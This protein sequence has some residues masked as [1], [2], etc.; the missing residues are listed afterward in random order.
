MRSII[1][2]ASWR[3]VPGCA[4][5]LIVAAGCFSIGQGCAAP[6]NNTAQIHDGTLRIKG[7]SG[8]SQLA[9][10]LKAGDPTVLEVDVDD[11]GSAD[12]SFDR[13]QFD[14][15]LV[16]GGKGNDVIRIDEING[17]FTDT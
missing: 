10:R 14:H 17:V 8:D 4:V 3:L 1:Y 9:L 11:D 5:W 7:N 6:G 13:A 2:P 16:Q 15:I 12:F